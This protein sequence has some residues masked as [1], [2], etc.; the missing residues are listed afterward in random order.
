MILTKDANM[1]VQFRTKTQTIVNYNDFISIT[2]TNPIGCCYI[3]D[4]DTNEVNKNSNYTLSDCNLENGYFLKGNC[5][6]N[7]N[8][9]PSS[10]GCCCACSLQPEGSYLKD[11]TFCECQEKSGLWR[12]GPCPDNQTSD[13]LD[14]YCISAFPEMLDYREKRACC[15]PEITS[16]GIQAKCTD[17]CSE[18]ECAEKTIIPYS[19]T[20]FKTGRK[21]TQQVGEGAPVSGTCTTLV[22][23]GDGD[24]INGCSEGSNTFC[25]SINLVGNSSCPV[26]KEQDLR[27]PGAFVKS[28][29]K[30]VI[31]YNPN[32]VPSNKIF[33]ASATRGY[34]LL[35]YTTNNLAETTVPTGVKKIAFGTVNLKNTSLQPKD[36]TSNGYFAVIDNN[37]ILKYVKS[38][39]FD[40]SIV[41]LNWPASP[42][43]QAPINDAVLDV[44]CADTFSVVVNIDNTVRIFGSFYSQFVNQHRGYNFSALRLKKVATHKL[45]VIDYG[46]ATAPNPTAERAVVPKNV[47]FVGQK[48]NNQLEYFTPFENT[49]NETWITA[50]KNKVSSMPSIEYKEL[51][52]GNLTL[53][54]ID[55]D[56]FLHCVSYEDSIQ[57]QI[58]TNRRVKKVTV[59]NLNDG[60]NGN[61]PSNDY[62]YIVDQN[63]V[64]TRINKSS[65]DYT[66]GDNPAASITPILDITC[67]QSGCLVV[68]E[69]DEAI[70]NGQVLGSCCVCNADNTI[71]CSQKKRSECE[72]IDG[73]FTAGGICCLTTTQQNCVNCSDV[74]NLC[75]DSTTFLQ[76]IISE[77]DLP[78][79]ELEYFKDG[80]YVG[81]F[82]PGNPINSI[83]SE[84]RGSP[85]TGTVTNYN[86]TVNAYGSISKKWG[87][88]I[89]PEDFEF[90]SLYDATEFIESIQGSLHDGQ[91]NT[92]GD[93]TT[94]Y[95]TR[96]KL[97]DNIRQKSRLSGWYLP[98]KQELEFI[99]KKV[100]YNFIIP[101]LFAPFKPGI[102]LTSSP[103]YQ[104]QSDTVFSVEKQ[105]F[106]GETFNYGQ[107]FRKSD[108][109]S[110][111]LVSR[112]HPVNIRLIRKI[113][114]E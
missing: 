86:P 42:I 61:Y 58:P 91:W 10:R 109:G 34:S 32:S 77:S 66:F 47:G 98:S 45:Q 7:D 94:Y 88:V 70:C 103:F 38:P 80:L 18:K 36:R 106:N 53:C 74:S 15:H 5:D 112:R 21:C 89:H 110:I 12:L 52:L 31:H 78:N 69:P 65:N 54:G 93:L 8:I 82:E 62:I 48:L 28:I 113:E 26:K 99:N 59:A 63:D 1:S 84:V 95:G 85:E 81:V 50:F 60:G 87:I 14:D 104:K 35:D 105:S 97:M 41:R 9:L 19:S 6:D 76:T 25:W 114:L 11:T 46:G 79:N 102:Y 100:N 22:G 67:V 90:T 24:V 33:L 68:V 23:G 56:D 3:Y 4:S 27:H 92:Y 57:D 73:N 71:N 2:E 107:S 16:T 108:Y 44:A 37:N 39:Y 83:G 17:V 111:Y 64:I 30:H 51:I 20:F 49:T 101:D 96:S 40:E 75:G 72:T 13:V 43:P 55:S 29:D